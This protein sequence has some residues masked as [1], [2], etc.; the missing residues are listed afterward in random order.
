MRT[1]TNRGRV[2]PRSGAADLRAGQGIGADEASARTEETRATVY[3]HVGGR[4][5]RVAE[6]SES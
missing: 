1:V 5:D 3:L 6:G 4:T 2:R